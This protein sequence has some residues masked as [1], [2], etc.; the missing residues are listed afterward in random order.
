MISEV[1]GKGLHIGVQLKVP[2]RPIA[3]ACLSAGLVVNATADNVIR[4]MPPL[5]ISTDFLNQ[6][7]DILESVFKQN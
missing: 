6:G 3:E 7:L 1:R 5:T 4:I 2:S